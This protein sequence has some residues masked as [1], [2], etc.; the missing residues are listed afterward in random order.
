M[1]Y[2]DLDN[3]IAD[4][5]P[6]LESVAEKDALG[7]VLDGASAF[8][9][10]YCSRPVGYFSPSPDIATDRLIAGENRRFLRLPVHVAGTVEI[11][12]LDM[13]NFFESPNGWIYPVNSNAGLEYSAS[14]VGDDLSDFGVFHKNRLYTVSARWGYAE[15]PAEIVEA[16]RQITQRWFETQ[17][18]ILGQIT[19]GGF[20]VERDIPESART[21]LKPFRRRQFERV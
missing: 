18:G 1:R 2:A 13:T 11:D 10:S 3:L 17:K 4:M 7:R 16:V 5:L 20:V 21:I 19:P 14:Y 8:I 12:G 9:D 6:E 15:T